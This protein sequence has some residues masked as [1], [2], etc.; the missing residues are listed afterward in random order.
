MNSY[1]DLYNQ[2]L[3]E[4][5]N[6]PNQNIQSPEFLKLKEYFNKQNLKVNDDYISGI[7]FALQ[8]K[9]SSE[10]NSEPVNDENTPNEVDDSKEEPTTPNVSP[11][12]NNPLNPF[13]KNQQK[14]V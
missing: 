10:E 11:V 8:Q 12:M 4:Y 1:N 3:N 2:I 6:T 9:N 5:Q 7:L 14:A 13:N